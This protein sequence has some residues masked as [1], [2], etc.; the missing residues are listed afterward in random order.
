MSM[1]DISSNNHTGT[2]FD[3]NAA[4]AAGYR[5][6]YI[7]ATQG[8]SYTNPYF[9]SDCADALMAGFQV[10]AYHFYTTSVPI[11]SQAQ[12]FNQVRSSV[13]GLT[14]RPAF[15][16]ESGTP[17]QVTVIEFKQ[18]VPNCILYEDRSFESA[19]G[20]V[21]VDIWLAWPGW[22]EEPPPLN[23]I[24]LQTG[25][26]NVPGIGNVD[27]DIILHTERMVIAVAEGKILAAPIVGGAYLP[28][29][30]GY[31]LVGADGGVFAFNAP[32]FG[33]MGGKVLQ[34]PIVSMLATPSGKG[35]LLIGADG[36]IY[37]FGDAVELGS[38]PGD[39]FRPAP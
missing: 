36:G 34:R 1:I 31:W 11:P 38:L 19:I 12:Y 14:L 13:R 37:A 29:Q 2:P 35:Y 3:W 28:D 5:Y 22:N 18:Y 27:L 26:G 9:A 24:A 20:T 39:G 17:S 21:G 4:F 15:D 25:Q 7:K 32:F 8:D 33:S 10:G 16:Y 23:V 30:S 6:V